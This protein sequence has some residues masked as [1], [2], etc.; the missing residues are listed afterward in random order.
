[1]YTELY[2]HKKHKT[3]FGTL[4]KNHC[5]K[6]FAL[7]NPQ[8]ARLRIKISPHPQKN[9]TQNKTENNKSTF[10]GMRSLQRIVFLGSSSF[11]WGSVMRGAKK[12]NNRQTILRCGVDT[13]ITAQNERHKHN[14]KWD[15]GWL[16]MGW[17]SFYRDQRFERLY[18]H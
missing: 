4:L 3:Y 11:T 6:T 14:C 10:T 5:N 18:N 13:T 8:K 17:G 7:I 1:M 2:S 16:Y 15:S 9:P 12:N